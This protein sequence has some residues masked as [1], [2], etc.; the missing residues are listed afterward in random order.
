MKHVEVDFSARFVL[1][2]VE[3]GVSLCLLLAIDG[4]L[5]STITHWSI[6]GNRINSQ[7]CELGVAHNVIACVAIDIAEVLYQSSALHECVKCMNNHN[8]CI[9]IILYNFQ[10]R[11]R[12][13]RRI[14]I[15]NFIRKLD[16]HLQ[17]SGIT[18]F[19]SQYLLESYI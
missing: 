18:E 17:C 15:L 8:G 19:C 14:E 1:I 9:E 13:I 12:Q 10:Q 3:I 6:F 2:S 16:F 11:F 5:W 7:N 4:I